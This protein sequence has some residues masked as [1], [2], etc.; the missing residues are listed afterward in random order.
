MQRKRVSRHCRDFKHIV[1]TSRLRTI[2]KRAVEAAIAVVTSDLNR[3]WRDKIE[4]LENR[5]AEMEATN[6]NLE[7]KIQSFL[8]ESSK[9]SVQQ[10]LW[11]KAIQ[12]AEVH[13]NDIEQYNRRSNI[14]IYGLPIPTGSDCV[15][16]VVKFINSSLKTTD[17]SIITTADIDVAHVLKT[18][19]KN[20]SQ[21]AHGSSS[22]SSTLV[23]QQQPP[24]IIVR[25]VRRCVRDDILLRQ[26]VLKKSPV[27][28]A[29][30]L[31]SL[32]LK[33]PNRLTLDTTRVKSVWSWA[34]KIHPELN[35]GR[36]I[37]VK[38]FQPLDD[39]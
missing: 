11:E 6:H 2:I 9:I 21:Q 14:R 3:L 22:A 31:T 36:K 34:G 4:E 17:D 13:A 16:T 28:L 35:S 30:D 37:I 12:K 24:P 38:P 26:K 25:F 32:N 20:T 8:D 1:Y 39:I 29:D 7:S 15:E 27:S 5:L 18:R 23:K 19:N 33:V 10:P